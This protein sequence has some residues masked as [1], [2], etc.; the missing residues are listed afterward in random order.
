MTFN[1]TLPAPIQLCMCLTG[2]SWLRKEPA[3]DSQG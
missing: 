2:A 3:P 1:Q